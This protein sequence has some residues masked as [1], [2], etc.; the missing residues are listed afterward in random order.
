[1]ENNRFY[2][3]KAAIKALCDEKQVTVDVGSRMYAHE[4]Q[5]ANYTK[6]LNEW[7]Q[8]CIKYMQSKGKG[9]DDLFRE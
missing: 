8:L 4:R 3:H 7:D 1:M 5:W 6:E 2:Q 9:L